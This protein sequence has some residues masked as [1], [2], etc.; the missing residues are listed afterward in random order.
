MSEISSN[1]SRNL[2][3]SFSLIE[4]SKEI[5]CSAVKFQLFKINELFS[6][7]ILKKSKMHRD[8]REWE[9]PISFLPDLSQ[10][11]HKLGMHFSCTPFYLKAVEE[12][13]PYVDFFKISSYELIWD[14]LIVECARTGKDLVMSTGMANTKEISHA[15]KTFRTHSQADLVLLHTISG[16]PTPLTETN[17]AAIETLRRKFGCEVGLSD[18]SVLPSVINRAVNHWKASLVEFHIDLDST[19]AEYSQ[20]HCWLPDDIK[21]VIRNIKDG[22][23]ADGSG[24]KIPMQSEVEERMWRADPSDGLR[25]VKAIRRTFNG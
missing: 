11:S 1:H 23:V 17:L 25:P 5:G 16:Y 21:T 2:E 19:G 14:D 8:R 20:G 10:Y 3:R 6:D 24:E 18:H 9:L 12:L 22:L 13:E 4:K 7:E 15:V